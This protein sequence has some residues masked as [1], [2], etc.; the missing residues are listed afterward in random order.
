MKKIQFFLK[1]IDT[2]AKQLALQIQDCSIVTLSGALGAGKTTLSGALLAQ[3]EVLVPVISPTFTYVNIYKSSDGKTIYH[4]DL[5]RLKNVQEFEQL[6]FFEYLDQPDS[7]VL[8]EWPEIVLSALKGKI[9]HVKLS[10][11]DDLQRQ[12]EYKIIS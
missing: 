11:I 5:Y 6:G 7:F 1:D 2:I 10:I 8:I 3:F 4:F 9:C 12:I